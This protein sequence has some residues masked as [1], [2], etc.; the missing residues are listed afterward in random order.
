MSR[1]VSFGQSQ[2]SLSGGSAGLRSPSCP[3][4]DGLGGH[5]DEALHLRLPGVLVHLLPQ[6]HA[7]TCAK[8]C[9]ACPGG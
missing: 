2:L 8:S 3:N 7:V 4:G 9:P 6:A 1:A 5:G